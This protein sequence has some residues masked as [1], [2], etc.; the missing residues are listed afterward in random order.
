MAPFGRRIHHTHPKYIH[1]IIP[2]HANHNLTPSLNLI[3]FNNYQGFLAWCDTNNF[4]L[5]QFKKTTRNLDEF[6]NYIEKNYKTK[7]MLDGVSCTENLLAKMKSKKNV[8]NQ[9]ISYLM[10]NMRMTVCELG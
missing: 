2:H 6:C 5:L 7:S 1:M 10:R 8:S 9:K 3:L 4:S